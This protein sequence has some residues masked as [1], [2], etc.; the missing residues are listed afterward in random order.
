MQYIGKILAPYANVISTVEEPIALI[1]SHVQAA[2]FRSQTFLVI[3][4][5]GGTTGV[6]LVDSTH[7]ARSIIPFSSILQ[8]ILR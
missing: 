5:G 2:S 6:S 3:D 1:Y 8:L 7:T 4:V